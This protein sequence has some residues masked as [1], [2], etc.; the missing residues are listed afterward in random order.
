VNLKYLITAGAV[1]FSCTVFAQTAA[2]I[3][4]YNSSPMVG[5]GFIEA[6]FI[7]SPNAEEVK[8]NLRAAERGDASA[9]F[10]MALRYDSGQGVPQDIAQ[11]VK[12]LRKA[13][14]QNFVKAQYNLGCLYENGRGVSQD[15]AEAV[16]WFH[17]AAEQGY[18][19]AQNNLS[20]MYGRGQ[21]VPK[22]YT[23]AYVWSSIAVMSGNE[24][25]I[26]NRDYSASELSPEEIESAQIRATELYEEIQQRQG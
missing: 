11:S 1:L 19:S 8:R 20:A 10:N 24:S 7:R 15:Y 9:Q 16:K 6:R 5:K 12:W 22:N 26:N 25:A 21:G 17:K 14:D 3:R 13:A 23:E 2:G 4:A 18:G